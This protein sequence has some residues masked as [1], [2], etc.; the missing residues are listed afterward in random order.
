M[1]VLGMSFGLVLVM[2]LVLVALPLLLVLFAEVALA[3]TGNAGSAG[4]GVKEGDVLVPSTGTV[5]GMTGAVLPAVLPGG[6][7]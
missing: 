5:T 4:N 2:V 3:S 1:L 7:A 6:I